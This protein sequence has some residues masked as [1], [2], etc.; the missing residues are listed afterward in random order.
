M[1]GLV[2]VLIG[3]LLLAAFAAT[4]E[5]ALTSVS[6]LRMRSLAQSGDRAARRVVRLHE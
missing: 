1:S 2:V 5:T 3:A 4:A 6:R